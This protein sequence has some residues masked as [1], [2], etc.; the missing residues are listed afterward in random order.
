[1]P[2]AAGQVHVVQT[3]GWI[4][5]ASDTGANMTCRTEADASGTAAP[6]AR[7]LAVS[8]L[9]ALRQRFGF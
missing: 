1:M 6:A 3:S 8:P 9:R 2:L 7:R 4:T 5:L